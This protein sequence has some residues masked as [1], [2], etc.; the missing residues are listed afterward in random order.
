[1]RRPSLAVAVLV[2]FLLYVTMAPALAH[3]PTLMAARAMAEASTR[4]PITIAAIVAASGGPVGVGVALGIVGVV[5]VTHYWDDIKEGWNKLFGN[6]RRPTH[7]QQQA[8]QR[9]YDRQVAEVRRQQ[10]MAAA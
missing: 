6:K 9:E 7:E 10:D 1:M 3:A 2:P 4:E 5:A 8:A